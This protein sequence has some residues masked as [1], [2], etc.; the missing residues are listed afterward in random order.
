MVD[1]SPPW[2]PSP[3][4]GVFVDYYALLEVDPQADSLVIKAA[5]RACMV[6]DH[7]DQ[8]PDDRDAKERMI[9]LTR[10]KVVLLD[11][12][13]R[14]AY[15]RQRARWRG[16]SAFGASAPR[17]TGGRAPQEQDPRAPHLVEVD[18]RDVSLGR[19]L[20]GAGMAA[21]FGGLAFAARAVADR[22]SR[23]RRSR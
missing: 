6:R 4:S 12:G 5:Y 16:A 10:A 22:A 23:K 18:L 13:S 11:A 15:D 19:L 8:N 14:Y 9:L 3:V 20:V 17:W 2:H 21:M 1:Q 7:V